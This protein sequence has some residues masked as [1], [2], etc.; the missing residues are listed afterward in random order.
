MALLLLLE[1]FLEL[2][3]QLVQTTERL[4]LG[5]LLVTEVAF[6]LLAQP[7]FGDQCLDV[8]VQVFETLEVGAERPVE[9]VEVALVLDHHGAREEIELVHVGKH[10][11]VLERV[12]QIE[13][14]AYRDRNLGGTHFVEQA[15][16]HD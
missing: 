16:Q 1:A 9:F 6:E 12:D 13:Q 8:P 14:F 11:T 15:K 5:A 7:V 10:H 3:D 2:L 4:D